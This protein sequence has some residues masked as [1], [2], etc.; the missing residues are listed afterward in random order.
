[1]LLMATSP[2]R[3]GGATVLEA[4]KSYFPFVEGNIVAN[5]SLPS[6]YDNF[7]NAGIVNQELA[8]Q[9]EEQV[10]LFEKSLAPIKMA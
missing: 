9:L 10:E 3:R 6:F 4:T 5:Y 2:G 8:D 7:S 1:M